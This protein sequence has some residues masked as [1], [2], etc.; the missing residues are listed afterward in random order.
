M[1]TQDGVKGPRSRWHA[2][3]TAMFG[4]YDF[5]DSRQIRRRWLLYRTLAAICIV[6]GV[7]LVLFEI[8]SLVRGVSLNGPAFVLP[9]LMLGVPSFVL[10]VKAKDHA[11]FWREEVERER[12]LAEAGSL[13]SE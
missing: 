10:W 7:V 4:G 2:L 9:F 6:L 3:A 12:A 1:K 11:L 8:V 13:P 5:R